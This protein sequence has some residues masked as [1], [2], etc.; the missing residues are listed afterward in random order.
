MIKIKCH[1]LKGKLFNF[2]SRKD[3]FRV[4][5]EL[6]GK[7][8]TPFHPLVRARVKRAENQVVDGPL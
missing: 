5:G 4:R 3:L 1:F 2:R 6:M 7:M 8:G